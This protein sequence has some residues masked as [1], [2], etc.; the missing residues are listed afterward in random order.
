MWIY[1]SVCSRKKSLLEGGLHLAHETLKSEIFFSKARY[2]DRKTWDCK[3]CSRTTSRSK[4]DPR[5]HELFLISH[6]KLHLRVFTPRIHPETCP[7]RGGM[8]SGPNSDIK[9]HFRLGKILVKM[10]IFFHFA[11]V[12]IDMIWL[13]KLKIFTKR[14]AK[15]TELLSPF[16]KHSKINSNSKYSWSYDLPKFPWFIFTFIPGPGGFGVPT[17]RMDT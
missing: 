4:K 8:F 7:P 6:P 3:T 9:P 2:S 13:P 14:R 17:F 5:S 11:M 10:A 15:S 12:K 16:S 1:D